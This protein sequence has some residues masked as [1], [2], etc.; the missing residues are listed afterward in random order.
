MVCVSIILSLINC[1]ENWALNNNF[2]QA[3]YTYAEFKFRGGTLVGTTCYINKHI[4]KLP[5][6]S[7]LRLIIEDYIKEMII[8]KIKFCRGRIEID[9]EIFDLDD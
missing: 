1:I 6:F 3:K 9:K 8:T 2:A 4:V 5:F 7:Y